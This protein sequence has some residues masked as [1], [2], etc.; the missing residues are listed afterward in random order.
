MIARR[1]WFSLEAPQ[2]PSA[3][4]CRQ[5]ESQGSASRWRCG[6]KWAIGNGRAVPSVPFASGTTPQTASAGAVSFLGLVTDRSGPL[7]RARTPR[8]QVKGAAPGYS[9]RAAVRVTPPSLKTTWWRWFGS[10]SRNPPVTSG[11]GRVGKGSI[12]IGGSLAAPPLP[13]HRT[14]G[15]VSG[16]SLDYAVAGLAR[17]RSPG[18]LKKLVGMT[19]WSAGLTASRQGPWGLPAVFAARSR[20]TPQR[21][22]SAK[23]AGP[24]FHCFQA[25]A[26][27]RRLSHSSSLRN[28]DGVWQ[29]PK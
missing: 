17:E 1:R 10:G 25:M 23:R 13:H 20:P 6:T 14:Y 24:V 4:A 8:G 3:C 29:K 27:N 19:M 21:R 9:A 2:I 5:N 7:S 26:R 28:T 16:G 12:G 15:S 22:S 11:L 18:D